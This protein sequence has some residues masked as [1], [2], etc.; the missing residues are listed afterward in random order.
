MAFSYKKISF[1][2]GI[3]AETDFLS[4]VPGRGKA[5]WRR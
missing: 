2:I 4:F 1:F 3:D 5:E